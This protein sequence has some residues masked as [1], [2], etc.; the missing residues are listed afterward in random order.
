MSTNKPVQIHSDQAF[1][2]FTFVCPHCQK[3]NVLDKNIQTQSV[4][5]S[6]RGCRRI[7]FLGDISENLKKA[8]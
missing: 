8:A 4:L 7:I 5:C 6:D 2:F 1:L 3:N